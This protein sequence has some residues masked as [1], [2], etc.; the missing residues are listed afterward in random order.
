MSQPLVD[1]WLYSIALLLGLLICVQA[2]FVLGRRYGV[3][4]D[5]NT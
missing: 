5:A 2:G 4:G 1:P 3:K